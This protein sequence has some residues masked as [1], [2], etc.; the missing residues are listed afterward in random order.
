M[1]CALVIPAFEFH[2]LCIIFF[3]SHSIMV[4]DLRTQVS[5]QFLKSSQILG[6]RV[7]IL[8][9]LANERKGH[10]ILQRYWRAVC[11][12]Q[13]PQNIVG[14]SKSEEAE[15]QKDEAIKG[16]R[17]FNEFVKLLLHKEVCRRNKGEAI[18]AIR[19]DR[20]KNLRL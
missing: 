18:S 4:S 15:M 3:A 14:D 11:N 1:N 8:H 19:L 17:A 16:S 6:R 7:Q 9:C 13:Y 5:S 2:L 20:R 12:P 10:K